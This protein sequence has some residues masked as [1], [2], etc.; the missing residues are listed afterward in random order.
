M[1]EPETAP[2][3]LVDDDAYQTGRVAFLSGATI[4]EIIDHRMI[5]PTDD[6]RSMSF[7]VGYADELIKLLRK[8]GGGA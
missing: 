8:R 1:S 3:L 5:D 4:R 2:G 6:Q 7:A